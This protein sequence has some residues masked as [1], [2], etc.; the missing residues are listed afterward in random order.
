MTPEEHARLIARHDRLRFAA[1]SS[2]SGRADLFRRSRC[3]RTAGELSALE[4]F[5]ASAPS[6][7]ERGLNEWDSQDTRALGF[8]AFDAAL[9]AGLVAT[10]ESLH[11]GWWAAA[12]GFAVSGAF[13]I[14]ALWNRPVEYGPNLIDFHDEMRHFSGVDAARAMLEELTEVADINAENLRTKANAYSIGFGL[15]VVSLIGSVPVV[16]FRP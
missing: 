14:W 13:L 6:Q 5:A 8:L 4:V 15:L 16:A 11:S 3:M 9:A 1:T 12:A 7:F 10:Y 2:T